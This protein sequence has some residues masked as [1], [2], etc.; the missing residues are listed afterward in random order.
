MTPDDAQTFRERLGTTAD[1]SYVVVD[2]E[3]RHQSGERTTV[4]H[5]TTVDPVELG[6]SGTVHEYRHREPFAAGQILS[7]LADIVTPAPGW[8]LEEIRELSTLWDR[9]HLNTLR[10]AC[11]HMV[12]ADLVREDNGYGG[13]HISTRAPEN[14]C[15]ETGYRYGHAWLTEIVPDD[16]LERV[17]HL[18]RDRSAD[19]YRSRG[20]DGAGRA[21]PKDDA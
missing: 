20:Y 8:S 5:G 11:S 4:D 15:P 2:L 3:I 1:R 10:A 18:M 6:F 21:V 19:L 14:V 12:P 17:R 9:W 7:T 16:V 13:T